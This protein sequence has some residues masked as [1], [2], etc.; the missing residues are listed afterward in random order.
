MFLFFG[1][2]NQNKIFPNI[3]SKITD[4]LLRYSETI[5]A[6]IKAK[7][8]ED[9]ISIPGINLWVTGPIKFVP[10]T[11]YSHLGLNLWNTNY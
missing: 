4:G 8:L 6:V 1:T 11:C 2:K 7:L 3:I 9:N 10:R 5:A